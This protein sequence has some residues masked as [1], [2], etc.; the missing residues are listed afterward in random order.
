MTLNMSTK[1]GQQQEVSRKEVL[2]QELVSHYDYVLRESL[3]LLCSRII[4][5][6]LLFT[7]V[8]VALRLLELPA[9]PVVWSR[10]IEIVLTIYI[11]LRWYFRQYKLNDKEVLCRKGL[12]FVKRKV[13][14]INNIDTIHSRSNIIGKICNFGSLE[15]RGYLMDEVICLRN[16]PK[17]QKNMQ[18]IKCL[19]PKRRSGEK[20]KIHHKTIH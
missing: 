3:V 18:Y 2:R 8:N 16:I 11:I 20:R 15:L 13:L 17:P 12:L 7:G 10:S 4:F 6:N 5:I 19:L 14:L 1:T 9:F